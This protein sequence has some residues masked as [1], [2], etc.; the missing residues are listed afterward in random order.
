MAKVTAPLLSFGASGQIGKTQ[1]YSKWKGRPYVR[2]HVIPGYTNTA[3]Q[4]LTR[5]LFTWLNNVWKNA[6]AL[7][8]APWFLY[9]KGQVMTDRNAMLKFNVASMR[10]DTTTV[11]MFGSPGAKGGVPATSIIIT[12]GAGQVSVAFTNPTPPTGWTLVDCV[13]AAILEQNPQSGTAYIIKAAQNATS[14]VV[15]TGLTAG[16]NR[17]MAWLKWLK[18][19]GTTAYG[20]SISGTATVT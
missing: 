3:G 1:V 4:I 10:T 7:F 11:N 5:S 20:V 14:P 16:L 18:P 12:P 2:R 8:T 13:A 6:P 19:D 9:A 17:V 15:V